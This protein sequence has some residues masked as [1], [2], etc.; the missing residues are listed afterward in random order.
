MEGSGVG[1]GLAMGLCGGTAAA[2][3]SYPGESLKKRV[4]STQRISFSPLEVYRGV[5]AFW[6]SL[7]LTTTVQTML[8]K[9]LDR[10]DLAGALFSGSVGG[11]ASTATENVIVRTQML[12]SNPRHAIQSLLKEGGPRRI[13][14]GLPCIAV[15]EAVFFS[16]TI[17]VSDSVSRHLGGNA[18][19]GLLVTGAVGTLISHPFDTIATTQQ[20][21]EKFLSGH[22]DQQWKALPVS[23]KQKFVALPN[24]SEAQHRQYAFCGRTAEESELSIEEQCTDSISSHRPCGQSRLYDQ[25]S[26]KSS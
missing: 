17:H 24:T 2:A 11:V 15:R 12:S 21:M 18:F 9:Y 6:T 26:S 14:L 1:V 19:A 7:L 16:S 10:S 4:Q 25:R 20:V 23:E 22:T 13:F 8:S 3:V 5:S